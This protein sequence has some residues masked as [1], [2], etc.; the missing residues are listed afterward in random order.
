MG[1]ADAIRTCQ[2][3]LPGRPDQ[4][5]GIPLTGRQRKYCSKCASIA[6]REKQR[7]GNALWQRAWR[8]RNGQLCNR[9][10]WVYRR[11]ARAQAFINE[12]YGQGEKKPMRQ[13]L[14]YAF[15]RLIHADLIWIR[16]PLPCDYHAYALVHYTPCLHI[17]VDRK[18]RR[19]EIIGYLLAKSKVPGSPE[20]EEIFSDTI[21]TLWT[22]IQITI[23]NWDWA[24]TR[25]LLVP[26]RDSEG[27]D[28]TYVDE[29]DIARGF[30][31]LCEFYLENKVPLSSRWAKE[32]SARLIRTTWPLL[33]EY[34]RALKVSKSVVSRKTRA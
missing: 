24:G 25:L 14:L 29:V 30:H 19:L 13:Q 2:Y 32:R 18:D 12:M 28:I 6:R 17:P 22:L 9:R 34:E 10:R 4:I 21:C 16:L 7:A 3:S 1:A 26:L 31:A 15:N 33:S 20:I 27:R 5:H 23:N 11:V 8:A